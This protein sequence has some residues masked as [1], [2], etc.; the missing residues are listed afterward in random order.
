MYL[1]QTRRMFACFVPYL[2]FLLKQ[3]TNWHAHVSV[4]SQLGY[5]MR[6]SAAAATSS[7]DML[8]SSSID[9]KISGV[10]VKHG[11]EDL[12]TIDLDDGDECGDGPE[13]CACTDTGLPF[14]LQ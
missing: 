12:S 6:S 5:S 1:A 3:G 2:L 13:V 10:R 8:A 9:S 14:T 7:E 4:N 11:A